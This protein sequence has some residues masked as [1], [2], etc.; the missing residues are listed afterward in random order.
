MQIKAFE[1]GYYEFRHI[2]DSVDIHVYPYIHKL[3][4]M[5]WISPSIMTLSRLY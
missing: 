3:H 4:M 5:I 2:F 1:K